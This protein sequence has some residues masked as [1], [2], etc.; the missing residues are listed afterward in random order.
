MVLSDID[1]PIIMQE[2]I[3]V[4]LVV[5]AAVYLGWRAYHAVNQQDAGCGKGCGCA[6]DKTVAKLVRAGQ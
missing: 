4:I 2:L 3:I 6:A 1:T 5:L